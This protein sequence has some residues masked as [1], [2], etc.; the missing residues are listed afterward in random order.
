MKPTA[1][2]SGMIALW[3]AS[4]VALP[5]QS[6]HDLLEAVPAPAAVAINGKL[7]DWDRS[8]EMFVYN[9][10]MLRDRYSVRVYAMWDKEA[11]YLALHWKDPTPMI[12]NVDPDRAASEGWMADSFQARFT[13]DWSQVHFTA[14]YG[15]KHDKQIT[16]I[17]Y[18]DPLSPDARVFRGNG[19]VLRDA[20]GYQQAFLADTDQRGYVQEIRIPWSL[21]F[22][23]PQPGPGLSLRFTGEYFWGGPSGT[24]WPA[25]TWA[26]PINPANP[27]RIVLY[28]NPSAWGELRLAN[29]GNLSRKDAAISDER[30]QGPVTVRVAIPADATR[31]SLVI[32]DVQGNRV[33]NLASNASVEAYAVRAATGHDGTKFVEVPWDGRG[34][35]PWNKDRTLFLGEVV[36]AGRYTARG[37]T[38]AGVGVLYAGSFYNPGTPPWQTA[39]GTGGWL[40][41]H[42]SP[43]AVAA[44]PQD[45][46]SRGRVFLGD[47][48]GECG[49]GFIGLDA[50]GR[51]IWEWVRL[52]SGAWFLAATADHVYFVHGGIGSPGARILG[53]LN[54]A[55]GESVAF[56]SG[57]EI[58]LPE[59]ASGMAVHGKT[60]AVA[61][62]KAGKVLLLDADSGTI[63]KEIIAS[64]PKG[65]AFRPNGDLIVLHDGEPFLGVGKPLAVACDSQGRIYVADGQKLVI[66]VFSAN[67]EP[68]QTIGE[69]GGHTPGPWTPRAMNNPVS[70]AVEERPE[71]RFLWVTESSATP[72]R[73]SVWNAATGEF[74]R[75]YVGGTG[76]CGSGGAMSDDL[77]DLGISAGMFHRVDL[78]HDKW[79]PLEV[80]GDTQPQGAKPP[81]VG[82]GQFGPVFFGNG[83][84]FLSA[85]SGQEREYYT[86]AGVFPRVFMKRGDRWRCVAA[87]GSAAT[88]R[89]IVQLPPEYPQP[90]TPESVFSWSDLNGD[91][92]LSPDEVRWQDVGDANVLRGGWGY[93]CDGNLAW[94]HSG[95]AFKPERFTADGAPVY[96]VTKVEQ[97]PGDAA[98]A[99]GDMFRTKFG[100]LGFVDSGVAVDENN[101]IHGLNWFAGYDRDGR[102]RWKYPNYWLAVHGAMTAPMGMPGVVMGYLKMS[103]IFPLDDQHSAISLRGNTGQEFLLR[104]DGVYLAELFTD[105]RM[106]PS[107]LPNDEQIVGVPI[108]DT[109]LGGEPFSGWTGRQRDG[110]VR[111]TYGHTDVRVAEVV[112]LQTT[113]D[114]G[115]VSIELTD[116]LV[117]A[118]R[119]FAPAVAVAERKVYRVRRS[120]GPAADAA[121]ND[122][123]IV[124]RLGRDE[125]GRAQLRA[126]GECLHVTWKVFDTTP[127]VNKGSSPAEA[128]ASGD[129]VSLYVNNSRVLVTSL[130]GKPTAIVYRPHGPGNQPYTFASPVRKSVFTYVAE[131]PGIKLQVSQGPA[132]YTVT[133]DIPW[134]VIG[135]QPAAGAEMKGD[136]GILFGDDTGMRTAQRIQWADKETN[137]V[138][139]VPTEAEFE[140]NRWGTFVLE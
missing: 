125:V 28:Q 60:V 74:V 122:D 86:E 91:S 88:A 71:G 2:L 3:A 90:P 94:Y 66:E 62:A 76:Y 78:A 92:G 18:D 7:D 42:S 95:L 108:N 57:P 13:T 113:K 96:D 38:H 87:L 89:E 1:G 36:P 109:S 124:V 37:L 53:R 130:G 30:L 129:S 132:E 69:H 72:K 29:R 48:G 23:N 140:P 32:E 100:Y 4:A 31:F 118:C 73:V 134:S 45:S 133:A 49:V 58:T 68:E 117:A 114:I 61:M 127:L 20:S 26:D 43:C 55:T 67:G 112:G 64:L 131:E 10:R 101:V 35:G 27:V 135:L 19:P 110:K 21:L 59:D 51:K 39:D 33:R 8:G 63:T 83:N 102:L 99:R 54:P 139:D 111:M 44:V 79:S 52:G 17:A 84:H 56:A 93:R 41:D 138:N 106:A 65:V 15:S 77:S 22:K 82:F 136:I 50:T 119:E 9:A 103:G 128:F 75:D 11:L 80:L 123:A 126:D 97:L 121:V 116:S 107:S 40:S 70:L 120:A 14:W 81:L 5:P 115:P 47:H 105:Q 16:H 34:D 85:A 46:Q 12:N 25:V 137:V 6:N 24:K 98:H 104:D